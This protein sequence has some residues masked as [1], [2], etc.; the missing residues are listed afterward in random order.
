MSQRTRQTSCAAARFFG[1]TETWMRTRLDQ[2][3]LEVW[4]GLTRMCAKPMALATRTSSKT[5]IN[6][7]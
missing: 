6:T 3:L 5:P 2:T 7:S 1:F 4:P